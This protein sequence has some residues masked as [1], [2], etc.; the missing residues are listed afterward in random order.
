MGLH[1]QTL[2]LRGY[3]VWK[4]ELKTNIKEVVEVN[5]AVFEEGVLKVGESQKHTWLVMVAA[6]FG[7]VN[8]VT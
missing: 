3:L 6:I 7:D 8:F 2:R 5:W 1:L 4:R